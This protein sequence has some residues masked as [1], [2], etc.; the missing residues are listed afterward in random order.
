MASEIRKLAEN[1]AASAG[2][3]AQLLQ[4]IV[5]D[6]QK[7]EHA[8]QQ[9]TGEVL[10][11]QQKMEETI[12]SFENILKSAQKVASQVYE[13]SAISEQMAAGSEEIAASVSEVAAVT[14]KTNHPFYSE[15]EIPFE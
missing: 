5:K 7:T 10:T 4:D 12:E 14:H 13:V 3:I 15:G 11:G 2:Q 1:S 8:M 9:V 6:S